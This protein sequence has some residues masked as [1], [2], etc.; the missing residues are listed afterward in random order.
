MYLWLVQILIKNT[1]M[2]FAMLFLYLQHQGK[3]HLYQEK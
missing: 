3:I 1:M 2:T